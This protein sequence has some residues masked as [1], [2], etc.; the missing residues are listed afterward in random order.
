MALG[1]HSHHVHH[2]GFGPRMRSR[3]QLCRAW[4]LFL[5]RAGWHVHTEQNI[6]L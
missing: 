4:T 1:L 5:R 6:L 3:N 2:C